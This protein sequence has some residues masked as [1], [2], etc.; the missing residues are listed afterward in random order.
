MTQNQFYQR[1]LVERLPTANQRRIVLITGARYTGKATLARRQYLD[2]NY[3][4]FD[5]IETREAINQVSSFDWAKSVGHS[6][7]DE[8]QK[9]PQVLEKIKY[10]YDDRTINFSV[11]LGSSQI[12]LLKQI[13][14]SLAGRVAIFE[15]YPLLM[16]EVVAAIGQHPLQPPL[17]HDLLT[18]SV[19]E[20]LTEQPKVLLNSS[21]TL[22]KQAQTHLLTWGGM[23][24]LLNI[25]VNERQKWL[26]DYE[27]T[28]L[29]RDLADLARLNDLQ[30]FRV[31]QKVVG[32]RSGNLLNFSQVARDV[33]ISVDTARR[34]IEYLKLSY[35]VVLIP[36]FKR[37][38]TSSV[39]KTPKIFWLDLGILRSLIGIPTETTGQLFE[40]MVV[41][42]IVKW[43][44]T[45]QLST[46]IYFYRTH[47]GQELDLLLQ[48]PQGFLGIEVKARAKVYPNDSKVL[49]SVGQSLAGEWL[50]GLVIYNGDQLSKIAEPNIWAIPAWRL[51]TSK[52]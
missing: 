27:Y 4:N 31:L 18:H 14:E 49:R 45:M 33:S 17:L 3:L 13:R 23:P 42:E 47:S 40:T 36:P 48:T 9:V 51:L 28:Y 7:I 46:E 16:T 35:Q 6:I 29:E 20:V 43:L 41:A 50:G 25:A 30:P 11:L 5:A 21:A 39:I 1:F 38:L 10:A 15:L 34:Y 26:R 2:L 44:K 19:N 8:V 12:L 24:E 32:L 37:N 52:S 22:K